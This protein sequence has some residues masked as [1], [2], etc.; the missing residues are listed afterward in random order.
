ML[1]NSF[2]FIFIFLPATFAG[3]FLISRVAKTNLA[4]GWLVLASFIFYGWFHIQYLYLFAFSILFNYGCGVILAYNSV[5]A[6]H[7]LSKCVVGGGIA[8][9]LG[10]LGYFKYANF[11][12]ETVGPAFG[13]NLSF[14][15]ILL[16]IGI[17]FFT[18]QQIAFLVDRSTG[19]LAQ[20]PFIDY[21]LFVSFFPQL[22]AG[23][24]VHHSDV[25]PQFQR[26]K[27]YKFSAELV[28]GGLTIFFLGLFK[29]V[30]LADQFAVYA[31]V[32]FNAAL[33]GVD[34]TL[35][36]AWGGA[37]SYTLQLYFDFSA[38][39][40]MAIGLGALIGISLPL[41]FNSPYKAVSIIDFWRRWHITLSRF[42]RD[43]LYI[44]LGGG[45][46]GVPRKFANLMITMVLGGL[47]HGAGWTFVFWGF[48]HG[49]YLLINNLWDSV[50]RRLRALDRVVNSWPFRA[51]GWFVT[52]V[53]VVIGWVFF[54]AEDFRSALIMIRGMFGFH[55][56][57]LPN[58]V[59]DMIPGL[60]SV[61]DR[62]GSV[63]FLADG[64]VMGFLEMSAFILLG[65][66]ITVLGR[67]LHEMSPRMR[68]VLLVPTVSFTLQRVLF[69]PDVAQFIYFQF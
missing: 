38:Y 27:T 29:K 45:R 55:G 7:I 19:K 13:A 5:A 16:P 65:L 33:R 32:A 31:N 21:C 56:A 54:R 68:L 64:R 18:F 44:P 42:L 25:L 26:R 62:A 15:E 69:K 36:E 3:F 46:V 34:L 14:G 30:V 67:H 61:V 51:F 2:E 4:V 66:I 39:S 20:P 10:L 60:A 9:N 48:L 57:V 52:M 50:L 43:Y 17:S 58:Q 22:V 11:F 59:V 1:F 35:F 63:K 41:N 8:I 47:W 24:I 6:R 23:P 28:F 37:L 40:D 49:L 53:A 12:I